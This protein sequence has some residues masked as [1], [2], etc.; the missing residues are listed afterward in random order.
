MTVNLGLESQK[1]KH[2]MHLDSEGYKSEN[3]SGD[4]M[5][6]D[7]KVPKFS[8]YKIH[9]KFCLCPKKKCRYRIENTD[10]QPCPN[11]WLASLTNQ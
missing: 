5:S 3:S 2:T 9:R 10:N 1:I 6:E 8:V 4:E 7:V 11:P